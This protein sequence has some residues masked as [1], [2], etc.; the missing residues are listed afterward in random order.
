MWHQGRGVVSLSLRDA[1]RIWEG[2]IDG[3]RMQT[4]A[5]IFAGLQESETHHRVVTAAGGYHIR[6]VEWLP[7]NQHTPISTKS[8]PGSEPGRNGVLKPVAEP[9]TVVFLHGFLGGPQ[10]WAAIASALALGCR[11]VAVELPG[12]GD[13]CGT[14]L[15]SQGGPQCPIQPLVPEHN[16]TQVTGCQVSALVM[17]RQRTPTIICTHGPRGLTCHADKSMF[18]SIYSKEGAELA[19]VVQSLLVLER[20][21]V[22]C[23]R[24]ALRG[25]RRPWRSCWRTC[26]S[27]GRMLWATLWVHALPWP[28]RCALV[29]C[30]VL[31]LTPTPG[32][33]TINIHEM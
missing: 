28:L 6:V 14:D 12:H 17:D 7:N 20:P 24:T 16:I 31:H 32:Y 30:F 23:G 11:C 10:D 33:S 21:A 22:C 13:S 1:Q 25:W 27:T 19:R 2:D 3:P 26:A 9:P 8:G 5:P 4:L 18:M 15:H 29:G